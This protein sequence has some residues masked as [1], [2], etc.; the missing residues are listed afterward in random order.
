MTYENTTDTAPE[1]PDAFYGP[2]WKFSGWS[3]EAWAAATESKRQE[4]AR[5]LQARKDRAAEKGVA[6][7]A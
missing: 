5:A 4:F 2:A 6:D 7:H 1:V 3:P